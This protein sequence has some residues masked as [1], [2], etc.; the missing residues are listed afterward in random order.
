MRDDLVQKP[1]KDEVFAKDDVSAKDDVIVT[2]GVRPDHPSTRF[3]YLEAGANLPQGAGGDAGACSS[4][5]SSSCWRCRRS[6]RTRATC[7]SPR[8]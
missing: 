7:W 5:R 4:A 8:A 2:F 3:G 1:I 6:F